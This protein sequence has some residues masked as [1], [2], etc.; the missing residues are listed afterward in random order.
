MSYRQISSC[1]LWPCAQIVPF[2]LIW[3]R[4][5][6]STRQCWIRASFYAPSAYAS[7][8]PGLQPTSLQSTAQAAALARTSPPRAPPPVAPTPRPIAGASA[9]RPPPRATSTAAPTRPLPPRSRPQSRSLSLS[10]PAVSSGSHSR[11]LDNAILAIGLPALKPLSCARERYRLFS[12]SVL[13]YREYASTD[14]GPTSPSPVQWDPFRPLRS[15][16]R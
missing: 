5:M 8:A 7:G 14:G 1:E 13:G 9:S 4:W 11:N 6:V 16:C 2:S 3:G 15:L 12:H 10:A